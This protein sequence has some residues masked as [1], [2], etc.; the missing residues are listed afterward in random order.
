MSGLQ[1]EPAA[2]GAPGESAPKAPLR[3]APMVPVALALAAGIV[4]GRYAPLSAWHWAVCAGVAL[5]AAAGCLA[6]KARGPA[7]A[8]VA[9][10][11]FALAAV[12]VRLAYF[13][14][15]ANHIVT[16]TSEAATLATIRGR[17]AGTPSIYRQSDPMDYPREPTT[18]FDLAAEGILAG[19]TWLPAEGLVQVSIAQEAPRLARGQEVELCGWIS[20]LHPPPN[21]GQRD[22]A[23]AARQ[24]GK[25]VEL[26]APAVESVTV[27]AAASGSWAR[28]VRDGA[29]NWA[30]RHL[31]RCA[32][33]RRGMLVEAL[34]LGRRDPGLDDLRRTM[35]RGG[36][37]H[38][39]S[40]SGMHLGFFLGFVYLLCRLGT[41]G[42]RRSAVVVLLSLSGYLLLAEPRSPLLRS[43]FMAAALCLGVILHRR[44]MALN[45]LAAAAV[46]LLLAEPLDLFAPG[47]QLSFTIVAGLIVLTEPFRELLFGRWIRIRELMVFGPQER[48]RRWVHFTGAQWL[49]NA[50][51]MSLL[52]W[53]VSLPLVAYHFGLVS[54]YGAPLT[55]LVAPLV[56]AVIVPGYVSLAVA[57]AAP[58][59]AYAMGRLADA[60]AGAL[61]WAVE[62]SARLPA[63]GFELQPVGLAWVAASYAAVVLLVVHR[64]VPRGR[65][66]L[67]AAAG[68]VLVLTVHAQL[69]AGAPDAAELNVLAVGAGQCAIL[70]TPE[71]RTYVLDAGS[72]GRAGCGEEVL[73]PFLLHERLP[74]PT[75]AFI[76]HANADHYNALPAL[77]KRGWLGKVYLNE[78]FGRGRDADTP[79][80]K[81]VAELMEMFRR[82]GVE[83][84]RL[85]LGQ[86]IRL[87]EGTQVE[88]LWPPG[89]RRELSVNDTS[90]VLRITC[91]GRRVLVTGDV[92]EVAQAALAATPE[93]VRSDVLLLP[94]H[95]GWEEALPDF[96]RAVGP[97]IV[98]VSSARE[99]T[100]PLRGGP[101]A[102]SFYGR[103]PAEYRY[104]STPRD[105]WVQV[106]LGRRGVRVRTMRQQR[107]EPGER[108]DSGQGGGQ[109]E[110]SRPFDGPLGPV[111]RPGFGGGGS[112]RRGLAAAGSWRLET[113]GGLDKVK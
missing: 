4:A 42:P 103:L 84:V 25:L 105:G 40:I 62:S 71:G 87:D 81:A 20:R 100:A 64:R 76:S 86:T 11:I 113:L 109:E 1:A 78:Y 72:L 34:I 5:I 99:P 89:G 111:S 13:R 12:H 24:A 49:M 10:A 21:P 59:L 48:L 94:H 45:A 75:A 33:G 26:R 88:V 107:R 102:A 61:A 69:P 18:R 91:G 44:H 77:L 60:A 95:G 31:A 9:A 54:P 51:V 38:L 28:R 19:A 82:R 63:L 27:L 74:R 14:L 55:L 39:L 58:N 36:I 83:A 56:V 17:I 92:G 57:W 112:P 15:P 106:R 53:L 110:P 43:A 65:L 79:G 22:L 6:R 16:Y 97:E 96:V 7:S 46:V 104:C 32:R 29:A 2:V 90:L 68:I 50:V 93:R 98:L 8:A 23:A 35:T 37:A 73:V 47:F 41:L 3:R 70:R 67:A 66:W 80:E 101:R 108:Y 85:R 30:R 52:A